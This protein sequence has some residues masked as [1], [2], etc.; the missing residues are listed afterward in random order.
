[1]PKAAAASDSGPPPSPLLAV[2]SRHR[3]RAALGGP[4]GQAGAAELGPAQVTGAALAADGSVCRTQGRSGSQV[5][6]TATGFL[7]GAGVQVGFREPTIAAD[8]APT[9]GGVAGP[10]GTVRLTATVPAGA[11][12]TDLAGFVVKGLGGDGSIRLGTFAFPIDPTTG[13]PAPPPGAPDRR[14]AGGRRG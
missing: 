5:Q 10:D 9:R 8:D 3:H 14:P 1:M 4:E 6:L 2:R 12:R 13:C 11:V 7:P